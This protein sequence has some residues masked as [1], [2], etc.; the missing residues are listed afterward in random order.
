MDTLTLTGIV[1]TLRTYFDKTPFRSA[2]PSYSG[3]CAVSALADGAVLAALRRHDTLTIDEVCSHEPEVA[4]WVGETLPL[5]FD[6]QV[7]HDALRL[8]RRGEVFDPMLAS[9][10]AELD[11]MP[12]AMS[13]HD[14][15]DYCERQR[16]V[17][18]A[19]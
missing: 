1:T 14:C 19:A 10:A 3:G 6:I 17:G 5:L 12:Q 11:K 16:L 18:V 9:V 7:L 2:T 8:A 13:D 4:A 15:L